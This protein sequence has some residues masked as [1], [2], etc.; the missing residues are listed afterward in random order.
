MANTINKKIDKIKFEKP[1][2]NKKKGSTN[3]PFSSTLVSIR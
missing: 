1:T 3:Q 2:G